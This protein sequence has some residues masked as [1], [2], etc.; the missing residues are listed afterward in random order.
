LKCCEVIQISHE[1]DEFGKQMF[2]CRVFE[3]T[4]AIF[5]TPCDSRLLHQVQVTEGLSKD[6]QDENKRYPKYRITIYKT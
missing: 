2:L 3:R 6:L 1:K 4:E 5:N